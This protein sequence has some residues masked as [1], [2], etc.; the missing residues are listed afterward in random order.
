MVPGDYFVNNALQ[1]GLIFVFRGRGGYVH[2][3]GIC[4]GGAVLRRYLILYGA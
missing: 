4:I 1:P 3:Y 2:R